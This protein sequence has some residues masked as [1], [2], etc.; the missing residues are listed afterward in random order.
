M[1]EHLEME[2]KHFFDP[3]GIYGA[4][5]GHNVFNEIIQVPLLVSG[6]VPSWQYKHLVST[7]DIVPTIIGLLKIKHH[8]NFDGRYIFN[9]VDERPLL[10]EAS[11]YGYEK[12]ALIIGKYKLIYSKG[13]GVEWLFDLE[14]DPLEQ[15]P[16]LDRELT[17]IFVDKLLEMLREDEKS[18]IREILSRKSMLKTSNI[19]YTQ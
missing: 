11:A 18:Y 13:D 16:I 4:G 9:A 6:V 19:K 17:S 5:H 12:K 2:E 7:V 1:G 3:R 15:H 14:K 10:C 8:M